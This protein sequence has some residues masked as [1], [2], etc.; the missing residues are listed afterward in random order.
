MMAL[1]PQKCFLKKSNCKKSICKT[2]LIDETYLFCYVKLPDFIYHYI[3]YKHF[4]VLPLLRAVVNSCL[5]Q[6]K[7]LC[8]FNTDAGVLSDF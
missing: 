3:F 4:G 5:R 7:L 1:T 8:N 2:Q 6:N